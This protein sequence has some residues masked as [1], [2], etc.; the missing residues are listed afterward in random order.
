MNGCGVVLLQLKV[1]TQMFILM[2]HPPKG[3]LLTVLQSHSCLGLKCCSSVILFGANISCEAICHIQ[4]F[5]LLSC[6]VT[7]NS[8]EAIKEGQGGSDNFICSR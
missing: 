3:S 5:F 1:E 4:I 2:F 7:G 6:C 8:P